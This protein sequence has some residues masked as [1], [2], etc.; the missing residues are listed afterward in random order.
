[1]FWLALTRED[2]EEVEIFGAADSV[3]PEAGR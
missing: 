1:M 2:D 3:H